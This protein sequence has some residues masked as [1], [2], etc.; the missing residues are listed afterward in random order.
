MHTRADVVLKTNRSPLNFNAVAKAAFSTMDQYYPQVS[1][2]KRRLN[3]RSFLPMLLILND[4]LNKCA[5]NRVLREVDTEAEKSRKDFADTKKQYLRKQAG[6]NTILDSQKEALLPLHVSNALKTLGLVQHISISPEGKLMAP[7]E[8]DTLTSKNGKTINVWTPQGEL[9]YLSPQTLKSFL[10]TKEPY[11]KWR[12]GVNQWKI[13]TLPELKLLKSYLRNGKTSQ[14]QSEANKI[15]GDYMKYFKPN[16]MA[17]R[18]ASKMKRM[19]SI[20]LNG[21]SSNDEAL[22][23]ILPSDLPVFNLLG[24]NLE[25]ENMKDVDPHYERFRGYFKD[26]IQRGKLRPETKERLAEVIERFPQSINKRVI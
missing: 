10:L 16:I 21:K 19:G 18:L 15:Q 12:D 1:M 17:K 3:R 22:K 11:T 7:H 5:E 20:K 14:F 9:K 8:V 4:H 24:D 23:Y 6:S 2:D 26:L 25:S 13:D